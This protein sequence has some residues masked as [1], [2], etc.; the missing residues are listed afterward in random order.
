VQNIAQSGRTDRLQRL[1]A[2]VAAEKAA[3]SKGTV[4]LAQQFVAALQGI[5]WF[6]WMRL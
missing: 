5:V 4:H 3:L 1:R 6:I 2:A